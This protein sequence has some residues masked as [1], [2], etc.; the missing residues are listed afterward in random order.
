MDFEDAADS[1]SVDG[2][3]VAVTVNV[4]IADTDW[5]SHGVDVVC[6]CTVSAPFRRFVVAILSLFVA[7][8]DVAPSVLA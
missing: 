4:N 1:F 6:C 8:V 7:C 3:R 2:K 5:A